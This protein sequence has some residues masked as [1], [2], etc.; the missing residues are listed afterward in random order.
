MSIG[1]AGFHVNGT[2]RMPD[3]EIFVREVVVQPTGD[4]KRPLQ[5]LT[6]REGLPLEQPAP[7]QSP[8]PPPTPG[9]PNAG[10]INRPAQGTR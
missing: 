5:Y 3:G 1:A 2:V 9:L 10:G 7:E 8:K 6:W 4:P